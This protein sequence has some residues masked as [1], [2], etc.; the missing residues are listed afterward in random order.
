M[1][2]QAQ[3]IDLL[4]KYEKYL[5]ELQ[6]AITKNPQHLLR[7]DMQVVDNTLAALKAIANQSQF[8]P[9]V[10]DSGMSSIKGLSSNPQEA[11]QALLVN[12]TFKDHFQKMCTHYAKNN[13]ELLKNLQNFHANICQEKIIVYK[14]KNGELAL[15]FPTQEWRD[16]FIKQM[17]GVSYFAST[18]KHNANKACPKTYPANPSTL[19]ISAYTARNGELAVVFPNQEVRQNFLTLL[20]HASSTTCSIYEGQDAIYFNDQKLHTAGY[21]FGIH[22]PACISQSLNAA[23]A[24]VRFAARILGQAL[25]NP[26][27]NCFFNTLPSELNAKIISL[28]T[29]NGVLSEEDAL[30]SVVDN[31]G[32][33]R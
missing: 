30:T 10:V 7:C 13:P 33:P 11:I 29:D 4:N 1:I 12:G 27:N 2:S 18:D 24:D 15:K 23:H 32:K 14:A 5:I 26:N 28:S 3:A 31:L 22:A 21:N 17:G 25:R 9:D 16:N 8:V 6:N 19:F 20:K